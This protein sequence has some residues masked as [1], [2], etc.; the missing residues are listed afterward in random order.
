[1]ELLCKYEK[2]STA[3]IITTVFGNDAILTALENLGFQHTHSGM[4]KNMDG[5]Y[6]VFDYWRRRCNGRSLVL[7][8]RRRSSLPLVYDATFVM[9]I[10]L[11]A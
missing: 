11:R 5:L 10:N 7:G 3:S 9:D 6:E 2:E 4:L 1:M 8:F